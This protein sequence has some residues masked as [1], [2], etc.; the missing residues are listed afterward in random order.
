MHDAFPPG[1]VIERYG[2]FESVPEE[3]YVFTVEFAC[4]LD[5]ISSA[6]WHVSQLRRLVALPVADRAPVGDSWAGAM[7]SQRGLQRFDKPQRNVDFRLD[8]LLH[9]INERFKIRACGNKYFV[10]TI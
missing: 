8:K 6:G 10:A 4:D 3:R 9:L 1:S 2:L 5:A 7:A